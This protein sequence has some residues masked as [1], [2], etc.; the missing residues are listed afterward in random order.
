MRKLAEADV[1]HT[2]L[3]FPHWGE[4]VIDELLILQLENAALRKEI[5]E[6]EAEIIGIMRTSNGY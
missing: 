5:A 3:L 1:V 4:I 6:L 2:S